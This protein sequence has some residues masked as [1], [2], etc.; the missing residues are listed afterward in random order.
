VNVPLFFGW[1]G[2]FA[3]HSTCA[4]GGAWLVGVVMGRRAMV[5]QERLLRFSLWAGLASASLQCALFGSPFGLSLPLP[6]VLVPAASPP[7]AAL[8][9][10]P[11]ERGL[12][13]ANVVASPWP[14]LSL[15]AVVLAVATGLAL[16]GFVWLA[17]VLLRLRAALRSREPETDPRVLAAAAEVARNM[18]LQH[19]PRLSRSA[20]VA[21]PIAFGWLRP[22]ICLPTRVGELGDEP[23]RALLAHEVAHLRR[24]DPG[25][26]WLAAALQALFPWQL[27]LFVVRRRWARLVE[28]RCDALAAQQSSSTAVARCLLDVAEW[29]RPG[30]AVPAGAL[31][32]AARPSAL[33]ERIEFA[34]LDRPPERP[35]WALSLAFCGAS[36]S[37]LTMAAPGVVSGSMA[38]PSDV[39]PPAAATEVPAADPTRQAFRS[40]EQEYIALAEQAAQVRA[41]LESGRVS[42]ELEQLVSM[43]SRRLLVVE[44]L[45]ER[46]RALVDLRDAGEARGS[47]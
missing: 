26:T 6:T 34:L 27:L 17:S 1:L 47:R 36:L 12:V 44:R 16:G 11:A 40:L 39:A 3:L 33:R 5:F 28:L 31:G 29:V 13:P 9:E 32:M 45:R 30:G 18:G 2:T 7:V 37:S 22:E 42:P 46:L 25:W 43:L 10:L 21:T 38:A 14:D 23:L 8:A 19:S 41:E 24:G 20:A 15:G 35:R 4:L